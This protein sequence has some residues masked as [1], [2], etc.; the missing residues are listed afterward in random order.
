[1]DASGGGAQPQVRDINGSGSQ[2]STAAVVAS[3]ASGKHL[4]GNG[5]PLFVCCWLVAYKSPLII[6][7]SG[8]KLESAYYI[9]IVCN[10]IKCSQLVVQIVMTQ[11]M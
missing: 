5:E 7:S 4:R 2:A 3:S 6:C 9:H 10:T 11:L 8:I 1:M